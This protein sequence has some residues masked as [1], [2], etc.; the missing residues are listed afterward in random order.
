MKVLGTSALFLCFASVGLGATWTGKLID[1][2]CH[3]RQEKNV[4]APCDVTQNT[5]LFALQTNDGKVYKLDSSGNA[6]AASEIRKDQTQAGK[7]TVLGTEDGQT[8]KVDAINFESS[9]GK[10]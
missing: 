9:P 3:D 2:T 7:V 4:P 10:R 6:K 1:A 8:I 5:A